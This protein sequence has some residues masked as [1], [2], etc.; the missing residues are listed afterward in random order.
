[1][2]CEMVC[3]PPALPTL[4]KV[5][6]VTMIYVLKGNDKRCYQKLKHCKNSTNKIFN[7]NAK[8]LEKLVKSITVWT[9][10]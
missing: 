9:K 4:F 8:K 1:M 5:F 6:F 7:K 3:T 2:D 10:T